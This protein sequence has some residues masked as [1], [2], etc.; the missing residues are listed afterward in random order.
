MAEGHKPSQLDYC[1]PLPYPSADL[2]DD[3]LRPSINEGPWTE[4]EDERILRQMRK[5]APGDLK[6]QQLIAGNMNRTVDQVQERYKFL[7]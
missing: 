6:L 5:I 4:V 1:L 3:F 7:M 2:F